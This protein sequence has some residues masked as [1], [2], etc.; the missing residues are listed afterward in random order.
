M[1]LGLCVYTALH[2]NIPRSDATTLSKYLTKVIWVL[3]GVFAPEFVVFIA[4][5]QSE[6][7]KRLSKDLNNIFADQVWD[8]SLNVL[9]K[10][11]SPADTFCRKQ[12]TRQTNGDTS[13]HGCTVSMLLWEALL[14]I[15]KC[16]GKILM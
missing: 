1:T 8:P 11:W 12:K 6:H 4:W 16:R 13:G 2:V 9:V 15:R 14:S 3:L 10:A 7:A 5:N